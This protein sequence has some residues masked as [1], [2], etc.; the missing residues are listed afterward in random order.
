MKA[1]FDGKCRDCGGRIYAGDEIK[2]SRA[3]GARHGSAE[4]CDSYLEQAAEMRMEA[5]AE[6]HMMGYGAQ[7]R[8]EG[9]F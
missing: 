8:E 7:A 2:W 5:Y 4:V 9:W 3:S 1:K 6:A